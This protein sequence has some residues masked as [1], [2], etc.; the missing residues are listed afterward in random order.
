MG[1]FYHVVI[2]RKD[3][4]GEKWFAA[5]KSLLKEIHVEI[6]LWQKRE[7]K[8]SLTRITSL[9]KGWA[10]LSIAPQTSPG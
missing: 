4:L 9:T 2:K 5:L 3:G 10:G 7:G 8:S 1:L 6:M